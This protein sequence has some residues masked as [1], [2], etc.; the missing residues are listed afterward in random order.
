M[1]GRRLRAYEDGGRN[2]TALPATDVFY[3]INFPTTQVGYA[4]TAQDLAYTH[5]G[6]QTWT[7]LPLWAN[8]GYSILQFSSAAHGCFMG[9]QRC[10]STD[11]SG[12]TWREVDT[13]AQLA[14]ITWYDDQIAAM[15]GD[16]PD[17]TLIT[18]DR[19]HTWQSIANP[20]GTAFSHTY[21]M[22]CS[23]DGSLITYDGLGNKWR[24][25]P[26]F[27]PANYAALCRGP[28]L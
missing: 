23:A 21:F 27:V 10:V 11:D 17:V 12:R 9:G 4:W 26:G 18:A 8:N 6:G 22:Y 2:W 19:G 1:G 5:D 3:Y 13:H 7:H 16:S 28:H 14:V 24:Y 25:R 20:P 15:F